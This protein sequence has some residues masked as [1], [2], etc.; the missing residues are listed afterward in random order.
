MIAHCT[1]A[2]LGETLRS[3]VL[4][5]FMAVLKHLTAFLISVSENKVLCHPSSVDSLST[6]AGQEDHVSMGGFSARKALSVVRNVEKGQVF[7]VPHAI[8]PTS[9]PSHMGSTTHPLPASHAI[10]VKLHL[11]S[12]RRYTYL[13]PDILLCC[14]WNDKCWCFLSLFS[15]C[16][17]IISSLSRN[18]VSSA[19]EDNRTTWSCSFARAKSRQVRP[20]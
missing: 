4:G 1:A 3:Y 5:L 17:W 9:I 10:S 18:R 14:F 7:K 8:F 16:N 6:A 15:A 20:R 11:D 13:A 12:R 2:A 19:F